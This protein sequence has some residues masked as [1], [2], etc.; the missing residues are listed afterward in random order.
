M[1]RPGSLWRWVCRHFRAS[2]ATDFIR[3]RLRRTTVSSERLQ[4]D[5]KRAMRSPVWI[6]VRPTFR[7][8]PV[9]PKK[10]AGPVGVRLPLA[11]AELSVV[12]K[13]PP[14]L[15]YSQSSVSVMPRRFDA[16]YLC[17]VHAQPAFHAAEVLLPALAVRR[18]TISARRCHSES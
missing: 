10:S 8:T 6:F 12:S 3:R 15:V 16:A 7:R 14:F 2:V 9:E 11:G 1:W 13:S 18:E 5:T 4:R 17:A